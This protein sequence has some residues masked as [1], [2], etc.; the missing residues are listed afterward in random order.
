MLGKKSFLFKVYLY[1]L[2]NSLV[3]IYSLYSITFQAKGLSVAQIGT[4]LIFWSVSVILLQLPIGILS[5]RLS[6]RNM[7]IF[8]NIVV[9]V[10]FFIFMTCAQTFGGGYKYGL[11]AIGTILII[12][13]M[14]MIKK[15]RIIK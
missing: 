14:T 8:S 4:A 3:L 7:M 13:S 15:H 2:L 5:D 1:A 12:M 10:A 11:F 6:R 9:S